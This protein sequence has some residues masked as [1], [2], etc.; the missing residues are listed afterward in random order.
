MNYIHLKGLREW[1]LLIK[2][3][4]ARL[5]RM[6]IEKPVGIT[7]VNLSQADQVLFLKVSQLNKIQFMLRYKAIT[8]Y[9]LMFQGGREGGTI[10]YQVAV[11]STPN[12]LMS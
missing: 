7:R 2:E 6:H 3:I 5:K 9:G 1:E 10:V 8:S 11:H 4:T 12:N